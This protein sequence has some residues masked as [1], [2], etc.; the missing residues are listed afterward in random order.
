MRTIQYLAEETRDLSSG[1]SPPGK[2]WNQTSDRPQKQP[3]SNPS[4]SQRDLLK[5]KL[6]DFDQWAP[7]A[8]QWLIAWLRENP[9]EILAVARARLITGEL[10]YNG[11]GMYSHE[12][13]RLEKEILE[14]LADGVC[15]GH[16][17]LSRR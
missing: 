12:Q 8:I 2:R 15:Y 11:D 14:E 4:P 7:T 10:V 1:S 16:L 13:G 17:F 6:D 9:E 5:K 3:P